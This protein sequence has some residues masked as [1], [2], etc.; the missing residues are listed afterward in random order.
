MEDTIHKQAEENKQH[1]NLELLS[2][3]AM[4]FV[5]FSS[6]KNIYDFIGIPGW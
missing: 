6:D 5:E 3:T 1:K 2:N 4:Q